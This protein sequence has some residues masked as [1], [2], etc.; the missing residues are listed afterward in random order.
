MTRREKCKKGKETVW[1]FRKGGSDSGKGSRSISTYIFQ[2]LCVS[3]FPVLFFGFIWTNWIQDALCLL[4][5]LWAP[6]YVVVSSIYV[7]IR[8]SAVGRC[9]CCSCLVCTAKLPVVVMRSQTGQLV[10]EQRARRGGCICST[11][12]E[13]SLCSVQMFEMWRKENRLSWRHNA[14][15]AAWEKHMLVLSQLLFFFFWFVFLL[16]F[17]APQWSWVRT[18]EM[19]HSFT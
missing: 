8:G 9:C 2:I 10:L 5:H 6:I 13:S 17:S 19:L 3:H 4:P 7:A 11:R 12:E 15:K 18:A 1:E 16:I 14:D